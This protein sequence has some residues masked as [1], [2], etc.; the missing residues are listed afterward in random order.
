MTP[1]GC[2]DR[3]GKGRTRHRERLS[4]RS[5]RELVHQHGG[6]W[7]AT[8]HSR[9]HR[10]ALPVSIVDAGP[11]RSRAYPPTSARALRDDNPL[12]VPQRVDGVVNARLRESGA[13]E[14]GGVPNAA[15]SSTTPSVRHSD[16]P[17]SQNE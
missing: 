16:E 10:L 11:S 3:R 14:I 1:H 7:P 13:H 12:G 5:R 17:V 4:H 6:P 2:L 8:T 15:A 9:R